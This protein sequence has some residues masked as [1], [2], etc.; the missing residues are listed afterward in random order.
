MVAVALAGGGFVVVD[1]TRPVSSLTSA[2]RWEPSSA[3]GST[4]LISWNDIND[5]S[6]SYP[7]YTSSWDS[8]INEW[9][10]PFEH[11]TP[12]GGQVG[13]VNLAWDGTRNGG[14]F[15]LAM[16]DVNF[17]IS[18]YFRAPTDANGT[19]WSPPVAVL[20]ATG[21]I[22]WDYP[23][24]VVTSSGQI[25]IGASQISGGTNSG[26]Y[27]VVTDDGGM[28]WRGP[29]RV[30][31]GGG[32]VSRL[33]ASGNTY[34]AFIL[35]RFVP[36][37]NPAVISHILNRHQ[38]TDG[39]ITWSGPF[40]VQTYGSP[41]YTSPDT[42]LNATQPTQACPDLNAP[43]NCTGTPGCAT[44]GYMGEPDV[45]G[46]TGLGWVIAYPVND[47]GKN[48][49]NIC[50]ELGGC[51]TISHTTDLFLGGITTSARGDWWLNYATYMSAP[52]RNLPIQQGVVYRTNTASYL[53]ATIETNINPK[54]WRPIGFPTFRCQ[55]Q[56]C[57]SAGDYI[58]PASNAFTGASIPLIRESSSFLTELRQNFVR[59]PDTPNV[60]QFL[61]KIEPFQLGA[62]FRVRAL[63]TAAHLRQYTGRQMLAASTTF[64]AALHRGSRP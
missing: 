34:H 60:P 35:D 8:F 62:D 18:V 59:D 20:V 4:W 38:S 64:W 43:C 56:P 36:V 61:P 41:L 3:A 31:T 29:Y 49:I 14:R 37:G 21:N 53:G 26:Y 7:G 58:H 30:G 28:N 23:S 1:L 12:T 13:D 11:R 42:Y 15:V 50:S 44:I 40:Q 33:T 10:P 22:S 27:V 55:N 47:G 63:E 6:L 25:A 54:A 16:Q 57:F 46:S 2:H 5:A 52:N 39:G 32:G 48:S 24:V 9:R 19:S 17:P 45:A 51:V